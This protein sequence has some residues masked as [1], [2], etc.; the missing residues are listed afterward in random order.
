[1]GK[2]KTAAL[3]GS[4]GRA[5]TAAWLSVL[6]M[7]LGQLYNR[8]YVKA[9]LFLLAE[10]LGVYFIAT[11][12]IRNLMGLI[13]LGDTP[14]R[15]EKVGRLYQNVPGDHSIFMMIYG[16]VAFLF[17]ALFLVF[18]VLNVRDAYT[19]GRLREE[20]REAPNFRETL[21]YASDKGFPYVLLS[22]PTVGVL[23]FTVLPILFMILIAFTNY[24]APDH[25]PP[26]NLVDWVGFDTF[27]NLLTLKAWSRTFFGV[28]TWTVI[29]AIL[30][31]VTT[32]FGG[33]FVALLIEQHGIRFK[34]FWRTV[35]IIPYA[36]P[37][38]ISL[39]VMKNLLNDQFGP[40]NQYLRWMGLG[41]LP[42][43]N[44]PFW[45]K[46]TVLM[47]NMWIGIPVSMIL[48]LGVLTSIPRDLYEAADIDG[49]SSF[50]KFRAITLPFV[51]FQTTPVLI[52]QF[53]GNINN[54]NVIYLLTGGQPANGEYSFAGS[55]DLLVTWLY[56]LT[57]DNQ[58]YNFASAVGIIIFI[59][60]ASFS[61]YN[62][63]RSRSFKEE[64]MIQ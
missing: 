18:Y 47:V 33:I 60:I 43:L 63:R 7:G 17:L 48:V 32:Y 31:T 45:A 29:W 28:L 30:A 55:T 64:D 42:W 15:M 4:S 49:A 61:I 37:Q 26:K 12:L 56:K 23:F 59:I 34:A 44:D 62:Y 24:A 8:Q 51:L 36:I 22:L 20:G 1:M 2:A 16:L 21:R 14:T 39:L 6:C 54:F 52:M 25:I 40:I 27:T 9:A 35:F 46:V 38:F 5:K 57:L 11:T 58:R 19:V 50:R 3:H 53:A 10:A 41:G 13:T